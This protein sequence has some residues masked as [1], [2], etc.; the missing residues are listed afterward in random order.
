MYF[1]HFNSC[2]CELIQFSLIL[3]HTLI[4][5]DSFPSPAGEAAKSACSSGG[6]TLSALEK[7][8]EEKKQRLMALQREMEVHD[9]RQRELARMRLQVIAGTQQSQHDESM[10]SCADTSDF[11]STQPS[12]YAGESQDSQ[13]VTEA[14]GLEGESQPTTLAQSLF[15]SPLVHASGVQHSLPS[16]SQSLSLM[17]I[18]ATTEEEASTAAAAAAV[19][20]SNPV[21]ITGASAG[22]CAISPAPQFS[23]QTDGLHM[24]IPAMLRPSPART[25]N[26]SAVR[27][28]SRDQT[29]ADEASTPSKEAASEQFSLSAS[30]EQCVSAPATA[31][32][33]SA[34]L[35][36]DT[37]NKVDMG[38]HYANCAING[39]KSTVEFVFLFHDKALCTCV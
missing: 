34:Q 5:D 14:A 24:A 7:E 32:R 25:P 17:T 16:L 4:T 26:T 1:K 35:Q 13:S 29:I 30:N 23:P 9:L 36:D 27:S 3:N 8:I 11:V 19:A 2:L 28:P 39:Q 15:S 6:H 38:R 37:G 31:T 20:A 18:V 12:P 22:R 21:E 33:E 10:T